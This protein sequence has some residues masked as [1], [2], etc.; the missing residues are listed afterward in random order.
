MMF[1][2]VVFCFVPAV[3]ADPKLHC[4]PGSIHVTISDSFFTRNNIDITDARQLHFYQHSECFAERID[5]GYVITT[6]SPFTD[7]GTRVDHKG[8]EYTFRNE[9]VFSTPRSYKAIMSLECQYDDKYVVSSPLAITPQIRTLNFATARGTLSVAMNLYQRSDFH[10]KSKFGPRPSVVVGVPVYV[11][12]DTNNIFGDNSI[13]TSLDS[14]YATT[15][16]KYE[17]MKNYHFL[18]TGRCASPRDKTVRI[19]SNGENDKAR[20]AFQMFRWKNSQ[21]EYIYL[22]CEVYVCNKTSE[23]C[24]GSGPLCN[25][26]ISSRLTRAK[27]NTDTKSQGSDG[28]SGFLTFGP[29]ALAT[30]KGKGQPSFHT[31]LHVIEQDQELLTNCIFGSVFGI[32]L[33]ISIA[34]VIATVV[35]RRRYHR[36]QMLKRDSLSVSSTEKSISLPSS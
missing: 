6:Y 22:H 32:L 19:F 34:L 10:P 23:I 24:S 21:D 31:D 1:W 12:V 5:S 17:V 2:C 3:W 15:S 36:K 33:L 30:V 25:N 26:D 29:I 16:Q 27:R 7:C 8:G 20:F 18:I 11:S 28:P 4:N 14:C 9:I 13:V 35:K